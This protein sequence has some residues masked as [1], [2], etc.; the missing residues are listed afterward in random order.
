MAEEEEHRHQGA[1]PRTVHVSQELGRGL[2]PKCGAVG[3]LS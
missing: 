2:E 1:R 3:M